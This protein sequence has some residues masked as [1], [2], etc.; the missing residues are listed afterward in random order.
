MYFNSLPTC[1][2]T[3][4]SACLRQHAITLSVPCFSFTSFQRNSLGLYSVRVAI[5]ANSPAP[6]PISIAP[7]AP[8]GSFFPDFSS[9]SLTSY[10]VFP[11]STFVL[12]FFVASAFSLSHY[13]RDAPAM[14]EVKTRVSLLAKPAPPGH[15]SPTYSLTAILLLFSHLLLI[16]GTIHSNSRFST[17]PCC[18]PCLD[19]EPGVRPASK[20]GR[21]LV[22]PKGPR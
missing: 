2:L 8:D 19:A 14:R 6:R 3:L 13:P 11:C 22:P 1:L 7:A 18:V 5:Y 17:A 15:S 12:S 21:P 10:L 4:T 16:P 20:H 9:Q